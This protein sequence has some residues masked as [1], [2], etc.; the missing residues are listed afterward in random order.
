[1]I[2]GM[3]GTI[4]PILAAAVSQIGGKEEIYLIILSTIGTRGNIISEEEE[5]VKDAE[6]VEEEALLYN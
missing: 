6:D 3:L 5:E 2:K 4:Y 1:M